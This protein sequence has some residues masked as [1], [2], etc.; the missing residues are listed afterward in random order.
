[1]WCWFGQ[2]H[3]LHA[4]SNTKCSIDE[5]DRL[6]G[7]F[8][9]KFTRPKAALTRADRIKVWVCRQSARVSNRW[10]PISAQEV[11]KLTSTL[12]NCMFWYMVSLDSRFPNQVNYRMSVYILLS[13]RRYKPF[14][15]T[16]CPFF[17]VIS[18]T[19]NKLDT[20]IPIGIASCNLMLLSCSSPRR[21]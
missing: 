16:M 15:I 5:N 11:F 21:K 4:E 2:E 9:I 20:V 13:D 19:Q 10:T 7:K 12:P 14:A 18:F 3:R 6:C 1:M 17:S 8:I